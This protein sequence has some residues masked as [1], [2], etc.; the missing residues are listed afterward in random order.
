MR[1]NMLLASVAGFV[2]PLLAALPANAQATRTWISGVG[3]DVNPC[4]RTAPCKTWAGAISK[5]ANGGEIDVLDPGGF[6]QLTITKSITLDGSGGSI[7]SILAAVGSAINVVAQP[8]DVVIIRNV[9]FNGANAATNGVNISSGAQVT[10]DSCDIFDFV[11]T[12]VNVASNQTTTVVI[13]NTNFRNISV[14]G[15]NA[16]TANGFTAIVSITNSN[17]NSPFRNGSGAANGNGVVAAANSIVSVT[18]S[19]FHGFNVALATGATGTATLNVDRSFITT[20]GT[21]INAVTGTVNVNSNML[22]G[23]GNAFALNGGTIS[24]AGNNTVVGATAN[25][26]GGALPKL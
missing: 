10:I 18:E 6:G 20:S 23:N 12:G 2:L 22:T 11:G 7:G 25:P 17:F 16:T 4:S 21:G 5:T 3:D 9:R 8:T 14:N 13:R 24:S 1:R 26:N 19:Q 15:V